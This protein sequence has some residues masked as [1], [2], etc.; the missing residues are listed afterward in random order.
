MDDDD[1]RND[2]EATTRALEAELAAR[3]EARPL[4]QAELDRLVDCGV[5]LERAL[6]RA[7]VAGLP[8]TKEAFLVWDRAR[9]FVRDHEPLPRFNRVPPWDPPQA[10][11]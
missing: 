3:D 2:L 10:Q 8:I 1:A 4:S 11:P 9:E 6:R 5:G 7:Q